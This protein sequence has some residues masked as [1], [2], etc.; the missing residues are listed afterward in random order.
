MRVC[1]ASRQSRAC[2]LHFF[3]NNNYT[4]FFFQIEFLFLLL[5]LL[6]LAA[7]NED[8]MQVTEKDKCIRCMSYTPC[9]QHR[10]LC[11][12]GESVMLGFQNFKKIKCFPS[13]HRSTRI[14]MYHCFFR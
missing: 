5:I 11:D 13:T 6:T 2:M 14:N 3:K 1:E 9:N 8:K 12:E 10:I 4:R 7:K